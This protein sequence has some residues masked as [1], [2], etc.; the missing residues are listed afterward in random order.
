[1]MLFA[2]V[3]YILGVQGAT[4]VIHL[5]LNNT[6]Q[7][8]DVDNSSDEELSTARL[9]FEQRWNRSNELRTTLASLVSLTLIV[10]ALKQ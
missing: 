7:R 4:F 2:T 8:V 10:L 1:M 3:A 6:L 5:P 9:A